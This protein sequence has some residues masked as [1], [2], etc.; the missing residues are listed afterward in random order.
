MEKEN[1]QPFP[2]TQS[3]KSIAFENP[4]QKKFTAEDARH[5]KT[6][7]LYSLSMFFLSFASLRLPFCFFPFAPSALW[8]FLK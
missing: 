8:F 7:I 4:V 5:A 6:I 2:A 1:H 3:P